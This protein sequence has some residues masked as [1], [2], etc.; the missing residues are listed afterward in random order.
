MSVVIVRFSIT[1]SNMF[2]VAWAHASISINQKND[3]VMQVAGMTH[4]A[5]K[6]VP[7]AVFVMG[8]IALDRSMTTE[9]MNARLALFGTP[10]DFH[11]SRA[12]RDEGCHLER[13]IPKNPDLGAVRASLIGT[14]DVLLVQKTRP[15]LVDLNSAFLDAN[16]VNSSR[17][18]GHF[19]Q[20]HPA[21]RLLVEDTLGTL[22]IK[23]GVH[24]SSGHNDVHG[25]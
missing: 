11:E 17:V 13:S 7:K 14:S 1:R 20:L 19:H 5:G 24:I 3:M 15:L 2:V 18:H 12:V 10:Y 22:G 6:H 8:L 4:S 25:A 21:H 23:K 9:H 16:Y